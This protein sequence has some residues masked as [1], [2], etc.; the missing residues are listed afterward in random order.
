MGDDG[1]DLLNDVFAGV[2]NLE[3]GDL[4]VGGVSLET[5]WDFAR[6]GGIA[7]TVDEGPTAVEVAANICTSNAIRREILS[8]T[9]NRCTTE[10][11]WSSEVALLIAQKKAWL[12]SL[13]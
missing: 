9:I 7:S 2:V 1:S 3:G 8:L 10:Q 13:D 11:R 12:E 5:E 6:R 4:G